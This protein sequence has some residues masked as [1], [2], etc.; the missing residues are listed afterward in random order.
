MLRLWW[1]RGFI[2]LVL[3]TVVNE[4]AD[5]TVTTALALATVAL[6]ALSFVRPPRATRRATAVRSPV[7]GRW[8]ALNSP[9]TRVPSHGVRA[10]AQDYAVD[11]L[12]PTPTQDK[13]KLGWGVVGTRPEAFSC[14][15]EP[16]HA[17]ADGTVDAVHDRQPD[18]RA[19]DTWPTLV[20]MLTMEG[21]VRELLGP[22]AVL[23]NHVVVEH[24]GDDGGDPFYS[25]YAHL[26]RRSPRVRPG[27]RVRVGQLLAQVGSTGNTS[28]PHLHLQ[29]MDR[30]HVDAAAGL[31]WCIT[32][33]TAE[34]GDV[35]RPWQRS[36]IGE[37]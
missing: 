33:V 1:V 7:R 28:E 6:L 21:L 13:P 25:V 9:G 5:R 34:S 8:V 12:H 36:L 10:Y 30:P 11:L 26:R 29:L 18:Q 14:F 3:L 31:P 37:P 27:D 4:P 2:L 15:G 22:W 19:H 20:V 17:V 35:D 16:V 32:D 24:A 23:G